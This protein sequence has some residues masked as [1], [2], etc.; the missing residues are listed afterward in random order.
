MRVI[1]AAMRYGHC[2]HYN[3]V[4]ARGI[5][6][7]LATLAV[8]AACLAV[9][10]LLSFCRSWCCGRSVDQIPARHPPLLIKLAAFFAGIV[11]SGRDQFHLGHRQCVHGRACDKDCR[12]SVSGPR[13]FRFDAVTLPTTFRTKIVLSLLR[14]ASVRWPA[15]FYSWNISSNFF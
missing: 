13:P 9:P 3:H 1:R 6:Y 2:I 8:L 7:A 14:P 12:H 15:V 11:L 5:F 10:R 4:P